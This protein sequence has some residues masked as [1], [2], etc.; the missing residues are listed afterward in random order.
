MRLFGSFLAFSPVSLDFIPSI[1]AQND[2]RRAASFSVFGLGA[3]AFNPG[4]P[5]LALLYE[6]RPLAL[7]PPSGSLP[8]LRVQ[9]GDLGIKHHHRCD[10][11]QVNIHVGTEQDAFSGEKSVVGV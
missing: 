8:S 7:R 3:G 10:V 6:A 5:G 1:R 4:L 11:S 2:L 9:A